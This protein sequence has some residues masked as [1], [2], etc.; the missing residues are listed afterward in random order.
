MIKRFTFAII[1]MLTVFIYVGGSAYASLINTS[2]WVKS[3]IHKIIP[4][5]KILKIINTPVAGMYGALI[6]TGQIIYVVPKSKVIFFGAMFTEKGKNITKYDVSYLQKGKVGKI[7]DAIDLS[8]AIKIGHG[9]IK[10]IEFANI[11]CPFCRAAERMFYNSKKMSA[12]ITRYIYLIP[13][14]RIHPHSANMELYYFTKVLGKSD[15]YKAKELNKIMVDQVYLTKHG[16]ISP[17]FTA[18]VKAIK[19]LSYDTN[20]AKEFSINGVPYFIIKNTAVLGI[21]VKKIYKLLDMKTI[22]IRKIQSDLFSGLK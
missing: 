16:N 10:V 15:A 14:P 5:T 9:S 11:D 19:R 13:Q 20:L 4:R 6:N 18:S 1:F 12:K 8:K 21:N 3:D 2:P 22:N 17:K 7:L